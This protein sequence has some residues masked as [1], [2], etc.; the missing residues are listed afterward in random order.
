MNDQARNGDHIGP[1]HVCWWE[2]R[3]G[4]IQHGDVWDIDLPDEFYRNFTAANDAGVNLSTALYS[5]RDLSAEQIWTHFVLWGCTS[6][7][8]TDPLSFGQDAK[9]LKTWEMSG[10]TRA[11]FAPYDLSTYEFLPVVRHPAEATAGAWTS[12]WSKPGDA[13]LVVANLGAAAVDSQVTLGAELR[14]SLGTGPLKLTVD[15]ERTRRLDGA[16]Q[17]PEVT[18]SLP[19]EGFVLLHLVRE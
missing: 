11:R 5:T 12:A 2:G 3:R 9:T 10:Q 16:A 1:A 13:L 14:E 6:P 18:L 17:L 8:Y 19:A 7:G 4:G 15:G